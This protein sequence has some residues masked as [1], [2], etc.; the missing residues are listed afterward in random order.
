[1]NWITVIWP[2]GASA[3]IT[4]ALIHL[5]I[6]LNDRKNYVHLLFAAA[7]LSVVGIAVCELQMMTAETPEQLGRWIRWTHVPLFAAIV[8]IVW[9][10]QFYFQSGRLWLAWSVCAVRFLALVLN[11]VLTP[12]LNYTQIT[13]V[14]QMSLFRGATASIPEGVLSPWTRVGELS[15]LL[16][17]AFVLD[18]SITLWRRGDR[19]DR[20]RAMIIGGSM[21]FFILA[22]AGHGALIHA[23]L[24][25]SPY[26]ISLTFLVPVAAM[27]YELGIDVVQSARIARELDENQAKLREDE[28]RLEVVAIAAEFGMWRWN[29]AKDEIWMSETGRALFNL[30]GSEAINLDRLLEVLHP[31]D[32]QAFIHSFSNSMT[33]N[34]DYQ[35]EFRVLLPDG[36][37]RWIGGHG[38]VEFNGQS[39]PA[40]L[41]SVALDI[42]AR[43]QAEELLRESEAR[44]QDLANTVPMMI[45]KSGPD[46]LC[47]FFN[48]G[49]LEFTGRTLEQEQGNGW[50]E[51]VHPED[52][53]HCFEIYANS[54]DA[55]QEF[56]ME[57]RLR[58]GDGEYRWILD[59]GAPQFNS[60]GDFLGYIGFVVDISE[61][62]KA[63]HEHMRQRIELAHLSRVAMLGGAFWLFGP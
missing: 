34:G 3:C 61:R 42:T 53:D 7:A 58:R 6:W 41:R 2:M 45:W 47:T 39:K 20:R 29:V 8:F 49:W 50:A 52:F 56:M 4:I 9:F 19:A 14:R 55:R 17:L 31:D 12:N 22:T 59:T 38:R 10:V 5:V 32:H 36:R 35:C 26:L 18:A 21:V 28:D 1:M 54:F 40:F 13:A 16:L 44:F 11:F 23:G 51:G 33:G 60:G 25:K 48:K 30:G 37:L 57:Y 15:S 24:I 63:E 46:K 27:A 43:K 62:R